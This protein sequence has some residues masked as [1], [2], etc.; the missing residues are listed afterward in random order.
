MAKHGKAGKTAA[1]CKREKA[2]DILLQLVFAVLIPF[3]I[4]MLLVYTS[5]HLAR[6]NP[7]M[8][9]WSASDAA[10]LCVMPVALLGIVTAAFQ[11]HGQLK[12]NPARYIGVCI[13]V[14]A[15][16]TLGACPRYEMETD[17]TLVCYN[18]FN[19]PVRQYDMTDYSGAAVETQYLAGRGSRRWTVYV[20]IGTSDGRTYRFAD[21]RRCAKLVGFIHS[22]PPETVTVSG[23][24]R[25]PD[26]F[27]RYKLTE[28]EEDALRELFGVSDPNQS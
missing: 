13:A 25:L 10:L 3:G 19:E 9:S 17:H 16:S 7:R 22:L 4:T 28:S 8:L 14:I 1:V 18:S 24:D 20:T 26:V 12:M 5:E 15:V 11:R 23:A 21:P 27:D 6:A 2:L